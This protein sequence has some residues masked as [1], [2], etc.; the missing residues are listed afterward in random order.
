MARQERTINGESR[1]HRAGAFAACAALTVF[2]CG[3]PPTAGTA[4]PGRSV[5]LAVTP[6]ALDSTDPANRT[7][8]RFQYVGGV[9]VRSRTTLELSDLRIVGERLAAVSDEGRFFEARLV[10]DRLGH[11]TGIVEARA[12]PLT[13]Q[14]GQP[15]AAE[16]A[17]AEGFDF[18]GRGDRLVGFEGDH[19]IWRYPGDGGAPRVAVIPNELFA[20]NEGIEA[21]AAYP[22]GGADAYLVGSETGRIWLCRLSDTC[23]ETTFGDVLPSGF[24]LTSLASIGQDGVVALLGR[25]YHPE[26]GTRISLRVLDTGAQPGG[27]LVD[28]MTLA[29]PLVVDNFEGL[30]A[31]PLEDGGIRFYMVS[32]DNGSDTQHTYL[33]AFEWRPRRAA[34]P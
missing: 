3:S 5:D 8:G 16:N 20:S 9:E 24:G 11:L 27:D 26:R 34:A 2:A 10:F 21:I 4:L 25:A 14:R 30:A 17:D 1:R 12:A 7:I 23:E 6:I 33:L 15:L 32:D 29:P 13:D 28:E 22:P 18:L 31:V 19:R